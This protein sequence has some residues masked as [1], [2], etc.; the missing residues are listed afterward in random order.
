[1]LYLACTYYK[2]RDEALGDREQLSEEIMALVHSHSL[3]PQIRSK[4]KSGVTD[5][6]KKTTDGRTAHSLPLPRWPLSSSVVFCEHE[7]MA[8]WGLFIRELCFHFLMTDWPH[9]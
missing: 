2:R 9:S 6:K 5:T 8:F 4:G 7:A 1:M 3:A